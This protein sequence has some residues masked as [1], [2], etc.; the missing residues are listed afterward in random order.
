MKVNVNVASKVSTPE[1]RA[2]NG[3]AKAA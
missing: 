2:C 3:W 1:G